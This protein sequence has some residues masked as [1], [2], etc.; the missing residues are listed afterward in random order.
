[1]TVGNARRVFPCLRFSVLT[2]ASTHN[3]T[4]LVQRV[5]GHEKT[6]SGVTYRYVRLNSL[7]GVLRVIDCLDYA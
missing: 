2:K 6:Y 5:V 3:K 4:I 7:S 1:V